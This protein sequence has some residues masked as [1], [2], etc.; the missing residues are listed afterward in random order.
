MIEIK[1]GDYVETREGTRGTVAYVSSI[2]ERHIYFKMDSHFQTE[3]RYTEKELEDAINCGEF[4]RIGINDFTGK[5]KP[6]TNEI[7]NVK[8]GLGI[9]IMR[10]RNI[11]SHEDVVDKIN[12]IID[13][14]NKEK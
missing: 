2:M 6:L 11:S 7:I 5:I 12:E 9:T 8:N 1:V 13:Y 3:W 14:I 10:Q 4:K